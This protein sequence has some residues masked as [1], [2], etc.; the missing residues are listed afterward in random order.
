MPDALA[1]VEAA[2]AGLCAAGRGNVCL[3]ADGVLWREDAGDSYWTYALDGGFLLPEQEQAGRAALL[4]YRRGE[5]LD[6]E[7][8]ASCQAA[9]EILAGL[10]EA[11][12]AA[13]TRDFIHAHFRN[14]MIPQVRDWVR[15]LQ[16]AGVH[17]WVVSGTNQWLIRAGAE[18]FDIPPERVLAIANV[19]RDGRLTAELR[20]PFTFRKGKAAAIRAALPRPPEMAFGN[21]AN[22]I[23]ML[24]CATRLAVAVEPDEELWKVAEQRG[25]PVLVL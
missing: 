20:R 22:D 9:A 19:V 8:G 2:I 16:A 1:R 17:C 21:T 10:S 4:A 14:R 7:D 23:A 13:N 11:F 24:E 25:W 18:M 12:V 5:L 15:R 6:G 3:D